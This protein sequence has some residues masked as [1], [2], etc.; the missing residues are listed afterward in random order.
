MDTSNNG[1]I[2]ASYFALMASYV[3]WARQAALELLAL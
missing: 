3:W 2:V 1:A